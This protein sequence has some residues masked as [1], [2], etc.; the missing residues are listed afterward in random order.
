MGKRACSHSKNTETRFALAVSLLIFQKTCETH[1]LNSYFDRLF[2]GL[3]LK[4]ICGC[5][6]FDSSFFLAAKISHKSSYPIM[7][8][9]LFHGIACIVSN[10][11]SMLFCIHCV[12]PVARDT[13]GSDKD[14][15]KFKN[16]LSHEHHVLNLQLNLQISWWS[17]FLKCGKFFTTCFTGADV[18]RIT[19]KHC[20][21][22]SSCVVFPK[23]LIFVLQMSKG[24]T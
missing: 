16:I 2:W 14:F 12:T 23:V 7:I 8:N 1:V 21:L 24:V 22:I 15:S 10:I 6:N 17:I 9:H 11:C 20:K 13:Q 3:C 19:I 5:C 4:V 18:L